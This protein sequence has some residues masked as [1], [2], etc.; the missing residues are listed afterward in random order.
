MFQTTSINMLCIK[1]TFQILKEGPSLS[2]HVSII[3]SSNP[4]PGRLGEYFCRGKG[5]CVLIG[6][7]DPGAFQRE[8]Q[9]PQIWRYFT[10]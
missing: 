2:H 10:I 4:K 3:P 9:D 5:L 7:L 1:D 6:I 8:F